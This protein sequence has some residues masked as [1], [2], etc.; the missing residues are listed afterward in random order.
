MHL[1]AFQ[2]PYRE[3]NL[4]RQQITHAAIDFSISFKNVIKLLN[5]I[6]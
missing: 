1:M 6:I 3:K 5:S 2:P 4:S